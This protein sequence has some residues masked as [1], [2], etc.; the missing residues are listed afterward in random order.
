MVGDG[1]AQRSSTTPG[2]GDGGWVGELILIGGDELQD[3]SDLVTKWGAMTAGSLITM[4]LH[5][6]P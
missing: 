3:T 1:G 2:R 5:S 6:G 4:G